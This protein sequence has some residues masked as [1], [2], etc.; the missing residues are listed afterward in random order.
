MLALPLGFARSCRAVKLQYSDGGAPKAWGL[1]GEGANRAIINVSAMRVIFGHCPKILQL[2]GAA[3]RAPRQL[4]QS[5][6][7][8]RRV[9]AAPEHRGKESLTVPSAVRKPRCAHWQ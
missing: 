2:C 9:A 3:K 4:R 1:D 6:Q 8:T 7:I 5:A